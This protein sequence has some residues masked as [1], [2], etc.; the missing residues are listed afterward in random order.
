M[1]KVDT[2]ASLI[3]ATPQSLV[4]KEMELGP[5]VLVIYLSVIPLPTSISSQV[6]ALHPRPPR[7]RPPPSPTHSTVFTSAS[8]LSLPVAFHRTSSHHLSVQRHPS[9][10]PTPVRRRQ[11]GNPIPQENRTTLP[12]HK[13]I[14]HFLFCSFRSDLWGDQNRSLFPSTGVDLRF[15]FW[16]CRMYK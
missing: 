13:E 7:P 10:R 2:K 4:G 14:G 1:T 15:S 8:T 11:H 9:S 12:S 6:L 5:G 16:P 3:S